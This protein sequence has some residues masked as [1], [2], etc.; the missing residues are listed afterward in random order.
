M[1]NIEDKKDKQ[2]PKETFDWKESCKWFALIFFVLSVIS[3]SYSLVWPSII[4]VIAT[5]AFFELYHSDY[6]F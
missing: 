6:Y 1:Q 2:S 5:S 4:F 3:V